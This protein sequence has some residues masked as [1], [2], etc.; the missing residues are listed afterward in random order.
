MKRK[1]NWVDTTIVIIIV[2]LIALFVN[3]DKILGSKEKV[4]VSNQKDIVFVVEADGLTQD[5]ITELEIGDQIFSQNALQDAFVEEIN[6]E[7]LTRPVYR[8]DAKIKVYEDAEEV[9]VAIKIKAKVAFSG[10]YMDLGG[11]EIKVGLSFIMKTTKVEFPSTI[12]WIEV[13]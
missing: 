2:V 1:W 7:P 10:P 5:M 12:K 13:K 3:K 11:Q 6:I 9:K 8:S 4:D